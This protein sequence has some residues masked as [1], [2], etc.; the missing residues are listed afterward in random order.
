ML[1]L[2]KYI[3]E[4]IDKSSFHKDLL[5]MLKVMSKDESVPH[6]IFY[7]P[8]GSGKKMII[9]M[10]LELL[11]DTD[12][13]NVLNTEYTVI[14]SGNKPNKITVKQSNYHIVIEPNNNNF[15]RYLIQDIV[16]EYAKKPPFNF[17]KTKRAFKTVLINSIDNMSYY[18]QTSLRRTMEIYSGT[19]RFIM[20]CHTLSRVIDPLKSRC[21]CLKVP[22]PS[23]SELIRYTYVMAM[24]E[25]IKI[26]LEEMNDLLDDANGN[27]KKVIWFLELVKAGYSRKTDYESEIEELV[28]Y[29]LKMDLNNIQDIRKIFYN[30]MIT[31]ITG[32][33]I[34]IDLIDVLC[35][36]PKVP[37][38][39]KYYIRESAARIEHNLIRGRRDIIHLDA[40]VISVIKILYD[41]KVIPPTKKL[42]PKLLK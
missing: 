27:I 31:N 3:P 33:K 29:I 5:Q 8:E 40:F 1:L 26:S 7:G 30:I 17:F 39:A 16:K 11:Y 38:R 13:N 10:F 35:K 28:V 12:I 22:S 34:L 4:T 37:I 42:T 19:C 20:W 32:T 2:Y 18:A 23:R 36:S 24:K 15:D 25:K 6:I 21:I 14:G 9:K 41:N